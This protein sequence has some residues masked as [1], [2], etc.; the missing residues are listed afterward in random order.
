M[1]DGDPIRLGSDIF[2]GTVVAHTHLAAGFERPLEENAE[3]G[4]KPHRSLE[5]MCLFL[6]E[7]RHA[8]GGGCGG[9]SKSAYVG[10]EGCGNTYVFGTVPAGGRA[11]VAYMDGRRQV[12]RVYPAPTR[13][14]LTVT[15]FYASRR[16]VHTVKRVSAY[17]KSGT[18]MWTQ[19]EGP[20]DVVT[21]CD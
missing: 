14:R 6:V 5:T 7:G 10:D 2:G 15:F 1:R 9:F 20:D 18:R 12:A 16:G 13:V 11:V 4:E 19:P 3:R 17:A 8:A 21:V